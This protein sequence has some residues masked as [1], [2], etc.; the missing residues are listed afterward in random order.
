MS[1]RNNRPVVS[2][3]ATDKLLIEQLQRDG[4]LSYAQLAR[5]VD[6]SEAAVRQR[7]QR[8]IEQ[9]VVQIV[10]VTDPLRLGFQRQAMVGVTT[11][12][13][14]AA[15]AEALS[16]MDEVD[17]VVYTSGSFDLLIELV[18]EDDDHLLE[19]LNQIRKVPGVR[20]TETFT[21]LRLHKQSYAWGTR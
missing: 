12:G 11:L 18:C 16:A 13:D 14:I 6:L 1:N 17:Y 20:T 7:V 5:A 9:N 21:Y 3:D 10:A 19:L 4:R 2:L 15:V 8:L